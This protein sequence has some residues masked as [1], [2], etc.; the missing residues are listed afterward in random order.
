MDPHPWSRQSYDTDESWPIFEAYRD[1]R[2]PRRGLLVIFKGR[3]V[4]PI[5]VAGWF[6]EH[7]W[8]Q[9]VALFDAYLDD[10]RLKERESLLRQS[11]REITSEHME[12]LA[13]SR[14]IARRELAKLLATVEESAGEVVRTRDLIRLMDYTVKLDRLV[15]GQSTENVQESGPD[16]SKLSDSDL[17]E[18]E[19]K[20]NGNE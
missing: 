18:I 3:A 19:R 10:I 1:Q 20:L 16:L 4:N 17:A 7:F 2:P 11:E 6:R 12:I 8:E 13:H 5:K 9:R 15:R 14:E